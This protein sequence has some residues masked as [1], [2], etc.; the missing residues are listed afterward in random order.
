MR[1]CVFGAASSSIHPDYLAGAEELGRALAKNGIGLVFGGGATGVMGA[2]ARGC[3]S[4]S[5]E[6]IGVAPE[7]FRQPGVLFDRCTEMIYTETMR[8]RKEKMEA[9]SDGF[10]MAPGGIGT[11]EEFFEILTLRQL[12]R[13]KKPI[14]ILNLRG[15]FD[16]LLA[17]LDQAVEQGFLEA[18]TTRLCPVLTDP[19]RIVELLP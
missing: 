9:L 2:C 1:I 19:S 15:Y 14:G 18:E 17:M 3:A 6:I 5:G 13:H 16:P 11:L 7:F 12:G 4:L 8:Q 10:L